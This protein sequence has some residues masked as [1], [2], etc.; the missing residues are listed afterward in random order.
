MKAVLTAIATL[1]IGLAAGWWLAMQQSAEPPPDNWIAEINGVYVGETE[2]IAEMERRGGQRPG[3]YHE[4]DQK[5]E[6]LDSL[7][8]RKAAVRA[9]RDAGLDREPATLRAME[10]IL[11]NKYVQ[12][13]LRPRQEELRVTDEEI[14]AVYA[15]RAEE[16]S[17][18]ARRR[19]AMIRI[20]VP[21]QASEEMKQAARNRI[22]EAYEA[23]QE[24]DEDVVHFAAV[25]REYSDHQ[26]SRYRGGAIGWIGEHAT[27]RYR[28]DPVVVETANRMTDSGETSGILEGDDGLYIVRLVEYQPE[29][30]RPV[31]ELATGIRQGILRD[32]HREIEN[33]FREDLLSRFDTRIR[34]SRLEAIEPLG[35]PARDDREPPAVPASGSER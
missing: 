26:T 10:R 34:M 2:F 20:G 27:E 11:V 16:Y 23:V 30:S 3:Q 29:R 24:L 19:V 28:F 14:E 15:E 33:E 5:K 31:D 17:V 25:A 6:L 22:T 21:E 18:P 35:P 4:L 1:L 13:N 7:L 9:A 12:E 8:Y 32:R